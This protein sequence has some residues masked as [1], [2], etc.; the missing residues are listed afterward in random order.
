MATHCSILAWRI[1]WTEEPGGYS[2]Q[3]FKDMTEVIQH[4]CMPIN[5]KKIT[6]ILIGR[7]NSIKMFKLPRAIY[8]FNVISIKMPVTLSTELE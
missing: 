5:G 6:C 2:P 7:I 3:S 4:V 1:P 8:R